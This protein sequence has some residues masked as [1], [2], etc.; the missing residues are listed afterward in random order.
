MTIT[1]VILSG[2]GGTR[3]WPMSTPD[4][5]KQFQALTGEHTMFQLTVLRATDRERF[6]APIIVANAA[7]AH[8]VEEQLDADWRDRCHPHFGTLRAQ[9]RACHRACGIDSR[10]A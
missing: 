3:L 9:H 4:R 7:H 5:P 6:D 10:A 8:L 2:G 1:P